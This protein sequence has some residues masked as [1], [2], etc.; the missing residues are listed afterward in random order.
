MMIWSDPRVQKLPGGDRLTSL[1]G[2]VHLIDVEKCSVLVGTGYS[3][4]IPAAASFAS[5]H[6]VPMISP[7][8]T[9]L[10][11]ANKAMMPYLLRTVGSDKL[12]FEAFV[13]LALTFGWRRLGGLVQ[14]SAYGLSQLAEL[15]ASVSKGGL[16]L[17]GQFLVKTGRCALCTAY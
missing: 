2:A 16:V 12:Q 13:Q 14:Q 8:S 7:G 6:H 3:S 9:S 5:V 11:Y 10:E 1:T 17:W 15:E 4:E